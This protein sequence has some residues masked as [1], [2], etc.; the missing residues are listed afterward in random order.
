MVKHTIL[1]LAANPLGTD[2]L[3]LDQEA[4]A[5]QVELERSGHREQF[6]LVTRWAAEPLDLL[7]ELR[8][9]EPTIVHFSGHGA[10]GE[11][12]TFELRPGSSRDV[13]DSS[14][15]SGGDHR[16]GLFFQGTDGQPQFVS[17]WELAATFGAAG[18]SVRLV[19]LS[20]C[21]SDAHVAPLLEHV[22]CVVGVKGPVNDGAARSFAAGFYGGLGEGASVGAAFRQGR[23]AIGLEGVADSQCLQLRVRGGIEPDRVV[24]IDHARLD[25]EQAASS[26][27]SLRFASVAIDAR[28]KHWNVYQ[29]HMESRNPERSY[30]ERIAY[31]RKSDPL[32]DIT[33]INNMDI[34]VVLTSVGI[35]VMQIGHENYDDLVFSRSRCLAL[36]SERSLKWRA[37]KI[38]RGDDYVLNM[39]D[40]W[41]Q[42]L[43]VAQTH[44]GQR[45]QTLGPLVVD[46]A[47]STRVQDPIYLSPGAP[48]RYSL[49]LKEYAKNMPN[50]ALISMCVQTDNGECVSGEIAL[51][52]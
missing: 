33:L 21:Y 35:R 41:R 20:A 46:Q 52:M 25:S 43:G 39:P 44:D 49:V 24:V 47:L 4:R 7:R 40:V 8:K 23:A 51:Y 31:S 15:S 45:S 30:F 19:V 14:D 27:P 18:A 36:D 11:G 6:E 1:F 34:P 3:A 22:D 26:P 28:D 17:V 5:I 12:S 29:G 2:R 10:G 38:R 32:F 48:Y 50:R 42:L 9:L 37:F 16:P 13:S